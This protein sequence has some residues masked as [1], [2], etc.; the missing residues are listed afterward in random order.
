MSPF[1]SRLIFLAFLALKL[2]PS[3]LL[4]SVIHLKTLNQDMSFEKMIFM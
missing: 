2:K 3:D 1:K 4:H